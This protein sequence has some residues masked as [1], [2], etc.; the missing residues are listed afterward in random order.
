[1]KYKMIPDDSILIVN[2][3][4]LRQTQIA[5][6]KTNIRGIKIKTL[7]SYILSFDASAYV[8]WTLQYEIYHRL[9]KLRPNLHYLR[10][11]VLSTNFI[12]ECA[13][14]L[15]MLHAYDIECDQLPDTT[16]IY[17]ELKSILES[18]YDLKTN[19]SYLKE[20]LKVLPDCSNVYIDIPYPS[21]FEKMLIDALC[22]HHAHPIEKESTH[23]VYEYYHANNPR[24]E[25][26]AIAQKIIQENI[27][28]ALIVYCNTSY[29]SIIQR[30]FDRYQIPFMMNETS[31]SQLSYKTAAL[32]KFALYANV[33]TF[34][35]CLSQ[36]CFGECSDL[37]EIQ[38]I[39][40]YEYNQSYPIFNETDI[41]GECFSSFEI[42]QLISMIQKGNRRKETIIPYLHALLQYNTFEELFISID[43]ILKK[44]HQFNSNDIQVLQKIH[45]IFKDSI[46][47]LQEKEDL[48]ICIEEILKMKMSKESTQLNG[49]VVTSLNE[50]QTPMEYT[51]ICGATQN[52]VT[53]FSPLSKLFDE[54]YVSNIRLFPSMEKRYSYA[55]E[56]L[57]D[58]LTQGNHVII[59]YPLSNYLG[60]SFESSL[61][62]ENILQKESVEF[63]LVFNVEKKEKIDNLSKETAKEI[64]VRDNEI[65]G[66]VSSL[67]KYVGCPYAYFLKYGCHIPEPIESG[68]NVQK[69]GT[70]NHA[71]L[72]QLVNRY[73]KEY[74][75]QSQETIQAI[76]D[77]NI[78]DMKRVFPHLNFEL[79]QKRLLE[80]MIQN[81]E[82]LKESEEHSFMTPTYCERK[83]DRL[84]TIDEEIN[85]HLV[86]YIDRIDISPTAFR[87]IDYKSSQKKLEKDKV[88]SGQ[89]LQLCTYLMQMN[90]ELNV[91]PLGAFYYSLQNPKFELPYQ[92]LSRRSKELTEI[93]SRMIQDERKKIKRLQ[94]W[95]FDDNVEIMDDDATHVLGVSK[96]NAKGVHARQVVNIDEISKSIQ[97]MMT[98]ITK[99]ILSGKVQCEP[100]EAACLFCKYLSICRF[101][102]SFTEKPQLVELPSCMSKE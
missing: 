83:W 7:S 15:D 12:S 54:D 23:P 30:V 69:I 49:I 78:N 55:H 20:T 1:M 42:K 37:I 76:I 5:L 4:T 97:E 64:Y 21:L 96:T 85:L 73:G 71:I 87:I 45:Q 59:S 11:N 53:L 22:H 90:E 93:H 33:E 28:E 14:F 46:E 86:G 52:D 84:M 62:I 81:M 48:S 79:I 67:E 47:Y 25:I 44:F 57:V 8:S 80:S 50:Y 98:M 6:L 56:Q 19:S 3:Q 82:V 91:R 75:S 38:T 40:P 70:L 95:I 72:E 99:N 24:C 13:T 18:I 94:G 77:V 88:F 51:F 34:N 43:K 102:G 32:L 17:R 9:K 36:Q 92:K 39:Y 101:N 35:E 100:N 63:D 16:P 74:A 2:Q 61:E 10:N 60:K 66:S 26:E 27:Q 29:A 31:I 68:F 89:Q 41:K 65:R 58:K